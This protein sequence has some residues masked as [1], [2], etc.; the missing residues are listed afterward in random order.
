MGSLDA[1]VAVRANSGASFSAN[2]GAGF[3]V[4][5]DLDAAF[6]FGA[7]AERGTRNAET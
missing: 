3:N 5:F 7:G 6:S 4:S 2:S 1:L